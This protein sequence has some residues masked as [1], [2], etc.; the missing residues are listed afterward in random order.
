[1]NIISFAPVKYLH[2]NWNRG[3]VTFA[4]K[5]RKL[6][7]LSPHLKTCPLPQVKADTPAF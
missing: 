3:S 2:I 7:G 6:V 1:M 4:F 5:R